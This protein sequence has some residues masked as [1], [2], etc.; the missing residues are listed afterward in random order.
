MQHR[1]PPGAGAPIDAA[2]DSAD[3]LLDHAAV[4]RVLSSLVA[5]ELAAARGGEARLALP[6]RIDADTALGRGG[7][8]ADSLELLRLASAVDELFH[9][10]ESGIE[11]YLLAR[12]SLGEW[13]DL[14]VTSRREC[15]RRLT[16]RTS[17]STG[18][19]KRCTHHVAHLEEE[20]REMAAALGP[21]RRVLLCAPPHHIYGFLFGVLL[22][23]VLGA[24]A[25]DAQDWSPARLRRALQPG[26]LL[27][28]HPTHWAAL[29]RAGLSM[30]GDVIG[31]TSTAPCPPTL[32]GAL[33]ALGL[34]AM[35]E[36]YGSSETAGLG[37]RRD[38]S[39]PY[40]LFEHWRVLDAAEDGV[41]RL[42]RAGLD[43]PVC[44]PD[45]WA[46]SD[47]RSFR[48]TGRI[49]GAVQVGGINVFPDRVAG[50]LREHPAVADCAVRLQG[51]GAEARLKAF[52]VLQPGTTS[53]RA[54]PEIEGWVRDA[55]AAPERPVSIAIGEC[56]PRNALGKLSDWH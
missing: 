8:E 19:P 27:V 36:I 12:R 50:R 1:T 13:A 46:W 48:P 15:G 14:V 33:R 29:A 22:P 4:L 47:D 9:L 24:E 11:D 7:F 53:E 41:P 18:E 34:E 55:F 38:T 52:V 51:T 54:R 10:H 20:M 25:V 16:F 17:G 39:L 56:L 31:T 35:V 32:I 42:T 43:A 30:P 6:P 45:W 23:R 37:Y 28:S 26:D 3:A 2:P 44:A 21:R 40:R 49:D 5:T